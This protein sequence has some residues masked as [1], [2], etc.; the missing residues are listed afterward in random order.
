ML[1]GTDIPGHELIHSSLRFLADTFFGL[2]Q[3][4]TPAWVHG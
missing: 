3:S 1:N 4:L 2:S